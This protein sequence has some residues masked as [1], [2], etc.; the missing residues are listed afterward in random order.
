MLCLSV[1]VVPICLS[2]E[3]ILDEATVYE[4]PVVFISLPC[5]AM[6]CR[7]CVLSGRCADRLSVGGRRRGAAA[8]LHQHRGPIR[9]DEG[10]R[11]AA[12]QRGGWPAEGHSDS[13]GGPH[14]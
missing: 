11:E 4:P 8:V 6:T 10:Q 13:H 9:S 1:C 2:L 3:T 5:H 7:G 12:G 14:E